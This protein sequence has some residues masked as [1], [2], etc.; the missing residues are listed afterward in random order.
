[1]RT[2]LPSIYRLRDS[3]THMQMLVLL[4]LALG[5]LRSGYAAT[6]RDFLAGLPGAYVGAVPPISNLNGNLDNYDVNFG[7]SQS[8][9]AYVL[10][11]KF[12]LSL[13]TAQELTDTDSI[14]TQIGTRN[15]IAI[16]TLEPWNGLGAIGQS[17]LDYLS[18]KLADWEKNRKVTLIV[19]F[20]HEMNGAW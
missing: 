7:N 6:A 19:R 1:M 13:H 12:P 5:A 17:D 18:A 8:P 11:L 16:V 4:A 15:A 3:M 14:M 2:L 10:Y 9:A 20:A